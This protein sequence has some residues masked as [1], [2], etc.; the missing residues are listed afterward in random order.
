VLR[1]AF[2]EEGE[3]STAPLTLLLCVCCADLQVY[4]E[5]IGY[6]EANWKGD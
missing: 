3:A 5:D 2:Q 1:L 4:R 6:F